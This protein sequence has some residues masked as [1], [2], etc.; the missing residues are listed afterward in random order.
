MVTRVLS[1]R[2]KAICITVLYIAVLLFSGAAA[3]GDTSTSAEISATDGLYGDGTVVVQKSDDVGARIGDSEGG[4]ASGYALNADSQTDGSFYAPVAGVVHQVEATSM[5]DAINVERNRLGLA[6]LQ[7]DWDLEQ[8]AM[9][10]SA[11]ISILFSHD[12]PDGTSCF[13]A[14]PSELAALGENIAAGQQSANQAFESWRNSPGHYAN[15]MSSDFSKVGIACFE[16]S[17]GVLYWVQ[18]FGAGGETDVSYSNVEGYAMFGVALPDRL[19]SSISWS[20]S[21]L[22]PGVGS[23][24]VLPNAQVTFGGYIDDVMVGGQVTYSYQM[25]D[26]STANMDVAAFYRRGDEF[27]A[28][29]QNVGN[30]TFTVSY[31]TTSRLDST[32]RVRVTEKGE[33]TD[34]DENTPHYDEVLFLSSTGVTAGYPDG[35]FKPLANVARADMAAFLCRYASALGMTEADAWQPSKDDWNRFSDVSSATPHAREILW[36]AHV[37]ITEGFPDGTF[38]PFEGIARCDMAAFL[39]RMGK[40]ANVQSAITWKPSE[41]D[42]LAF[43]D[44]STSTPHYEDIL[45]LAHFGISTGYPDHTFKP[46]GNVAR[47]DMAA[48]LARLAGLVS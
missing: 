39:R 12:R 17:Y 32:I 14:F 30:T 15:M 25:F 4:R 5:L 16:D 6:S 18:C 20:A 40:L 34:V 26:W 44:V 19:I 43:T 36:L 42:S 41:A 47:C 13:T 38:R 27:F 23:M 29:G 11:E 45:W 33:F 31:P 35:S 21:L 9:Q 10:R 1:I 24:R 8:T 3:W 7:W 37:G 28:L 46:Y 48:F 2:K 22:T